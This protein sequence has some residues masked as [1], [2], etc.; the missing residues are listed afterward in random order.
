MGTRH[1]ITAFDEQGELK[2]A[3]YGQWDGY[4]EGQ[5]ITM[6]NILR[7]TTRTDY[8]GK[9]VSEVANGLARCRW[10]SED[11]LNAIYNSFPEMNYVG[12][13]DSKKFDTLYPNL[14]R[15]T[16]A[17]ILNVVAWSVGEVLLVDSSD[18]AEDE[19]FCEGIYSVNYQSQM[20]TSKFG[21]LT[22]SFPLNDLPTNQ[23][24]LDAFEKAKE[25]WVRAREY[26]AESNGEQVGFQWADK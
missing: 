7:Y 2:V 25:D 15:D 3:Q 1:L 19:L 24:Y 12:T 10:G 6:L 16:G 18:F 14:T 13:D 17:D 26:D 11:E 4:P 9:L 5:G 8:T 22:V 23:E 20:F 21:L